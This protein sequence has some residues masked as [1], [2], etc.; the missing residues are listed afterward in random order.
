MG[1]RGMT[2]QQA[3]KLRLAK[4]IKETKLQK[5]R[6]KKGLS[7]S[8]L[9]F[10]AGL[11]PATIRCYEQG[12][13]PLDGAKLNTLCSLAQSLDCKIEDILEDKELIEK[14]KQTK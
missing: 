9:S 8:E 5:L 2:P 14:Y 12:L 4:G 13:R 10:A 7:Q 6:V 3:E 1:K 11:S